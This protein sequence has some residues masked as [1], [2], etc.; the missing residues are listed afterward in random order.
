MT[1]DT[2]ARLCWGLASTIFVLSS[3]KTTGELSA[4]GFG[5]LTG[6]QMRANYKGHLCDL[7]CA[8]AL[9]GGSRSS[10]CLLVCL[11]YPGAEGL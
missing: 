8:S 3:A 5:R 2:R 10:C 4:R 1:A 6:S 11:L 9:Q 7:L